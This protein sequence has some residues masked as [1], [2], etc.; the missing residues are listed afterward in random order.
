MYYYLFSFEIQADIFTSLKSIRA[1]NNVFIVK[2]KTFT[3]GVKVLEFKSNL[4]DLRDK[5]F[6]IA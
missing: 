6:K 5:I 3:P 2:F 4:G 1:P